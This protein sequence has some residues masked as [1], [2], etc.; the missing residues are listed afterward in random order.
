MSKE[1]YDFNQTKEI[2]VKNIEIDDS[3]IFQDRWS[4]DKKDGELLMSILDIGLIMP[5]IVRPIDNNGKKYSL[6]SGYRRLIAIKKIGY[7]QISCIIVKLS[8]SEAM[9]VFLSTNLG[10]KDI[11]Y[12]QIKSA[13]ILFR[14]ILNDK[15]KEGIY[16]D[17]EIYNLKKWVT[18]V[19]KNNI[20]PPPPDNLPYYCDI[21][22]RKHVRGEIYKK[23][24]Y[25]NSEQE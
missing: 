3:I 10:C 17:K 23:H 22:K 13:T 6:V 14:G 19:E 8:N 1:L 7:K 11:S 4:N 25:M 15:I 20:P 2:N 16:T 18:N 24:S 21:C 5:I 9:G 12:K